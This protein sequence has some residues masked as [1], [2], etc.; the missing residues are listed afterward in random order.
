MRKPL[1][2]QQQLRK[3]RE[4]QYPNTYGES[5][6]EWQ[7]NCPPDIIGNLKLCHDTL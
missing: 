4:Q 2:N 6:K 1:V 5:Y 3:I 7:E